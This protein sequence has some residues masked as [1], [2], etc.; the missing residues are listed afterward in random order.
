MKIAYVPIDER[1][2]NV[3][4]VKR[5]ASS[6]K[7]IELLLP[8]GAWLSKKKEPA[9]TESLWDWIISKASE[10]DAII[11]SIDMLVYGGLLPSRLHDMSFEQGLESSERLKQLRASYPHIPVYASNVIM[12]APNYNSCD[13]EPDYYEEWG[14]DLFLRS[15]FRDKQKRT[16]LSNSENSH[17]REI[18]SRLPT[19]WIEDYEMRREYNLRI[20]KEILKLVQKGILTFLSIPQDDSSEYGY[21]AIDHARVMYTRYSMNLYDSVQIYPGAD[22]VGATLLSRAYNE[23][24]GSCPK[25]YPFWSS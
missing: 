16:G 6:S 19:K 8:E 1:P 4:M 25:I 20:N 11:V 7:D 18:E 13:E 14:R 23:F 24:Q 2:C 3:E 17:L 5:I 9:D 10:T 15:Y 21:T 12:R 22:E